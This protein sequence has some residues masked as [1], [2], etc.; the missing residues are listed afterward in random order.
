V[1]AREEDVAIDPKQLIRAH[2][3]ACEGADLVLV[4]GAGGLL[5]PIAA[6][7]DMAG[8]AATLGWPLVVV[9]RAALGTMNHTWLTLQAAAARE[10]PV[11]GVVVSH[12]AAELSAADRLNLDRLLE[13]LPVP[14]LGELPYRG[15]QLEPAL[16]I[17]ALVSSAVRG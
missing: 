8:L 1:A 4:E 9:A 14:L 3:E 16:D 5:V 15:M 17:R 2:A 13:D 10:L 6:E 12:T 7:L 11:A